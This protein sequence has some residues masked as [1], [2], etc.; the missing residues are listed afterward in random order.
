M[1]KEFARQEKGH[2][3]K[4]EGIKAGRR[5][6][7]SAEKVLDLKIADYVVK[8]QESP[9]IGYQDALILAM[10]REKASFKLYSDLAMAAES[11]D[12]RQT[13]EALA[14]EEAKH[15]LRIEIEYDSRI[16]GDN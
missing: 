15:K 14:Q 6:M 4:L 5:L 7:P 11:D 1:F 13:F 16:L 10:Q 9:D 8:V 12:L 3:A 2:K